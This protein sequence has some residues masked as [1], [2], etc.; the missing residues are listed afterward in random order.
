MEWFIVAVL[1][2]LVFGT[3]LLCLAALIAR[4]RLNRHHRVD[5]AVRTEAPITWLVD[6]RAPAKL[7]RRLARVGTTAT[8][9]VDDHAPATR[10]LRKTSPASPLSVTA[11]DLRAQAVLLDLQVSRLA[12]LAPG[13]RRQPLTELG[14]AIAGLESASARLVAISAQSRAPRGLDTDDT[15]LVEATRRIDHL[16]A[17]HQ[18]LLDLD[19]RNR[20]TPRAAPQ[21][22][23]PAPPQ[24]AP[25]TWPPT[26]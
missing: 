4:N 1:A 5:P 16:A 19:A 22:A 24:P 10:R 14:T 17:A 25:Q 12:V 23:P 7:H 8:T 2:V 3:S 15:A 18:E 6:P 26:P 11:Q 13:A 9:V 20:L 21:T